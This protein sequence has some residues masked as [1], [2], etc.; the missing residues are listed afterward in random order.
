MRYSMY[1]CLRYEPSYSLESFTRHLQVIVPL[2]FRQLGE[3]HQARVLPLVVV[4]NLR[5]RGEAI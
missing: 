5:E 4:S 1:M 3:I 2:S